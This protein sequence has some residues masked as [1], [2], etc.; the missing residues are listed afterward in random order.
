M[1]KLTG[2]GRDLDLLL[3]TELVWSQLGSEL[4]LQFAPWRL[5]GSSGQTL[6][7]GWDE[8][9]AQPSWS[10]E[11]Q[12]T[13]QSW[14]ASAGK[15]GLRLKMWKTEVFPTPR[16]QSLTNVV[17]WNTAA[18]FEAWRW[19]DGPPVSLWAEKTSQHY[20]ILNRLNFQR[21][22]ADDWYPVLWAFYKQLFVSKTFQRKHKA[23]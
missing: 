3:H 5:R 15:H 9:A 6:M 22:A 20:V 11:P 13:F 16:P 21:H 14:A 18:Q 10:N 2:T 4:L 19:I 23:E 8:R 12:I 17:S 1:L 7:D